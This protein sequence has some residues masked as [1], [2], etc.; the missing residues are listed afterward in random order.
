MNYEVTRSRDSE[1]DW[2]VEAVNDAGD[3]EVYVAIFT[4][5]FAEERA[6]EYAAWRAQADAD[7]LKLVRETIA[8]SKDVLNGLD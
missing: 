3:G 5:P 2:R 7:F 1:C 6:R 4:G 8:D